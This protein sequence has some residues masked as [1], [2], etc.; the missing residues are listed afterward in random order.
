GADTLGHIAQHMNGIQ[1][2]NLEKLGLGN[3]REIDGVQRVDNPQAFYT[4]MQEASAMP[5]HRIFTSRSLL[6]FYTKMKE[7]SASKDTMTGHWEIM[8]LYI[9]QPFQTF[10]DG[11]PNTLIRQLEEKTGRKVIG[12]KPA[13]GTEIIKELGQKHI[14]TG[15]LIVYTSADS[16]LQ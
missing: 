2:P 13:S 3:I 6:H 14:E 15:S 10:P 8:C 16:V 7:A 4:K 12:N 11:F 9:D 1:L 5:C